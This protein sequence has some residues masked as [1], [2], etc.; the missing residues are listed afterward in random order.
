MLE[1][2]TK[3]DCNYFLYI[4]KFSKYNKVNINANNYN[5]NKV[6]IIFYFFDRHFKLKF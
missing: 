4:I 6:N 5:T 3:C 2:F 1:L